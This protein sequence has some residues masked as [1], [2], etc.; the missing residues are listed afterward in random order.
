M[1]ELFYLT[2][3]YQQMFLI[4]AYTHEGVLGNWHFVTVLFSGSLSARR[5]LD[6]GVFRIKINE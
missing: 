3:V 1:I 5:E 6:S 2:K 4:G